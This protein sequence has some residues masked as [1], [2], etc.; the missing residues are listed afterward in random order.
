MAGAG[1][2]SAETIAK[3]EDL[4]P[5]GPFAGFLKSEQHA[6]VRG[7]IAHREDAAVNR[8]C[9]DPYRLGNYVLK[10]VQPVEMEEGAKIPSAG[11][12]L[13]RFEVTR[14]GR[15]SWFN[16]IFEL[17]DGKLQVKPV[18]PGETAQDFQLVMD[19]RDYVE[20]R[21]RIDNCE[22]RG[23][24]DTS[25]GP[26]EGYEPHVEGGSY[27]TWT[28]SGCGQDVDMVLLFSRRDDGKMDVK[29]EKQI[30]R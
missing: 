16:A 26:P 3:A 2:A 15:Q 20:K 28:V 1:G 23:L 10:I 19:L 18:A 9:R 11:K 17:V 14:C 29:L 22:K 7:V 4:K 21:A 12:W 27:E 30:P 13:E 5:D 8:A 6:K 25:K 24:L